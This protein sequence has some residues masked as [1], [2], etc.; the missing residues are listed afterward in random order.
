MLGTAKVQSGSILYVAIED[1]SSH[2]AARALLENPDMDAVA[3]LVN[4]RHVNGETPL[5]F[6]IRVADQD[7]FDTLFGY[8]AAPDSKVTHAFLAKKLAPA[9]LC[10]RPCNHV[11]F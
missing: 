4:K 1:P 5:H 3:K 6:T 10:P 9:L 11:R 7:W 2:D 8:G